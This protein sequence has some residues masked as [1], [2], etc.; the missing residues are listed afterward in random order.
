MADTRGPL[1]TASASEVGRNTTKTFNEEI[2]ASSIGD[3]RFG[4]RAT[5]G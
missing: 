4:D 1:R 3:Q 5:T 2:V